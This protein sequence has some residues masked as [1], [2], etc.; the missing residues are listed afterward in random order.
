MSVLLAE[1]NRILQEAVESHQGKVFKNVGDGFCTVFESAPDALAAALAAQRGLSK[2]ENR[3]ALKFRARM[4]LHSGPAEERNNDYFGQTL[5]RVAR[6]M[7]AGSGGQTLLTATVKEHLGDNLPAGTELRDLGNHRLRDLKEAEHIFQ[8]MAPDLRGSFPPIKSLSPRPTN[9]PGQLTSFVGRE[10]DL[11]EICRIVR[12]PGARLVTLLGPGGI[13]KTRLSIQVG[14]NL[15]DEYEDGVFFVAL[16]PVSHTDGVL[17]TIAQTLKVQ[18]SGEATLLEAVN[19]HLQDRHLL[20]VLDNFEQIIDA[21]PLVNQLLAASPYL[22]VVTTSREE[23]MIYGEKVYSVAPLTLPKVGSIVVD[24][25]SLMQFSAIKLF[26]DRVQLLQPDFVVDA[27]NAPHVIEICNRL[28]GLPLAIELAAVRIRDLPVETIAEQLSSRLQVLSKGPRDFPSRQRTMRGAIEWSYGMLPAE[29]QQ[30]FARLSIFVGPFTAEAADAVTGAESLNRLK[31]KSLIHEVQEIERIVTYVMLETL[32]EYAMEQL[33]TRS[34]LPDLKRRHADYYMQLTETAEPNLT[35]TSQVEWFNRLDIENHNVQAALEWVWSEQDIISAGRLTGVLWRYW[36]S[37]SRLSLGSYWLEQVL[38]R[39]EPIPPPIMAK[40]MYGA[41]RLHFLQYRYAQSLAYLKTS[42]SLYEQCEDK[43]GQAAIYLSLGEIELRQSNYLSAE[44]YFQGGLALYVELNDQAG[45]A[46]CLAQLGQLAVSEGNLV[47]AESLLHQSLD[48]IRE[49]GSIESIAMGMN[50]LADVLRAQGKYAEAAELYRESIG[51]YH[52]LDFDIG[53]AVVSHNLGQIAQ[54]LGN[55]SEALLYFQEAL[56]L[57]QDMEEKQ[58]IA[59][60]LAG[61]GGVF[62]QTG[63]PARAVRFLSAAD[64]LMVSTQRQLELA[65]QV[66]YE[67]H[68]DEAHKHFDETTWAALWSEGKT[69][70]L[71]EIFADALRGKAQALP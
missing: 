66:N 24:M 20:L 57:L 61:I 71:E 29:E 14:F 50:D 65:D 43:P 52:T 40:M 7:G 23:L 46:R 11:E 8:L 36:G 64:T 63:E 26:L 68:M 12:Q 27:S 1:H 70:R 44:G 16:A 67:R 2:L 38:A 19:A 6:V 3:H 9:L 34:E 51:H 31:E 15:Q 33:I 32:R 35:G 13:G 41:G 48:L 30:A 25:P 17:E 62:L 53:V 28:D 10:H 37:H 49:F 58:I 59:E 39:P 60:C 45:F 69:L 4:G 5:N 22:K 47:G 55:Y 18:E 42:L 56:R 54:Q 21:A